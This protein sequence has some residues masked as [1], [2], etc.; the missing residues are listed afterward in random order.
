[1]KI[2]KYLEDSGLLVKQKGAFLGI[3]EA[4]LGA[5]L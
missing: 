4:T 3:L 5:S 2:I 1:M